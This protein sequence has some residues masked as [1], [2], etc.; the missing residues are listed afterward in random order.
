MN[1]LDIILV[2]LAGIGFVKGLF[3]GVIKPVSYTHL[4]A[5]LN[6]RQTLASKILELQKDSLYAKYKD[7][8]GTIVAA[9]VYQVWK[10]E[11]LLLD[12]MCIRDREDVAR[13]A[14][15]PSASAYIFFINLSILIFYIIFRQLEACT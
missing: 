13:R 12:E 5:I 4:R 6:L 9:D 3:D 1:W 14:A 11:I 10:K 7:K 2:C 8:I 15:H